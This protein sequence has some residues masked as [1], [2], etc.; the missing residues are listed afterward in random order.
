MMQWEFRS[1]VES[2]A[3]WMTELRAE[4]LRADLERLERFDPLR[5]RERFL[6]AFVPANTRVIVVG[7]RDV[8]LVAVRPDVDALWIEH[9]Y[10]DPSVQ[11]KG[12]GGAVLRTVLAELRTA[13]KFRLNVLQGSPA[14]S[15]YERHGFVV[16]SEDAVDVFMGREAAA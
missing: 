13:G 8:G 3:G 15:L 5:V 1:S 4:V 14:R 9:F 6:A 11:G 10:I 2:D 7:G 12:I 16:E